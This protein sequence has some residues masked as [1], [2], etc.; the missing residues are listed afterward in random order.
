MSRAKAVAIAGAA[1]LVG[2]AALFIYT[3]SPG[4]LTLD[5]FSQESLEPWPSGVGVVDSWSGMEGPGG[6][7]IAPE[8]E[9][10]Y[11]LIGGE[12]AGLGG[13]LLLTE[14]ADHLRSQGWDLRSRLSG[15]QWATMWGTDESPP[16]WF[17]L[18]LF[19]R[20]LDNGPGRGVAR[21]NDDLVASHGSGSGL[22]LLQ[23]TASE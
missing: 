2:L 10:L 3:R 12:A 6:G 13:E 1:F 4:T 5:R 9:S 20:Y 7:D 15:T 21:S 11:L 14:V 17:N 19:A 22:V 23:V 8:A 16:I 18:G